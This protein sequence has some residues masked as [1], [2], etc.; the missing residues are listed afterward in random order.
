MKGQEKALE[1]LTG[2]LPV[3]CIRSDQSGEILEAGPFTKEFLGFDPT[4]K[5]LEDVFLFTEGPLDPAKT[6]SEQTEAKRFS[7]TSAHGLP[8]SMSF[9]FI[10]EGES[11][12]ILGTGDPNEAARLR[13]ELI[14]ANNSLSSM[15][16]EL[17]KKN[18]QLE[19][20]NRLKNLFLGMA[21]HD[22]R[23]P[24][25]AIL[26][27]T[28]F[29]LDEAAACLSEEHAGFLKTIHA[30]TDLMRRIIDDFLDVAMIESGVFQLE[31]CKGDLPAA[32]RRCLALMELT[33]R[34]RAVKLE[35]VLDE[36]LPPLEM[37]VAKI[38]QVM[39]N[40]ISNAIEH[41]PDGGDVI[42]TISKMQDEVMVCVKDSGPGI[43][44]E[45]AERL[46]AVFGRGMQKK[47]RGSKS[48]GLGLAISKK[49]MDAHGGRIWLESKPGK[50]ACFCFTLPCR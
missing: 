5:R 15:T 38:E 13:K 22:L 20:L 27:Y 49:I 12:L 25:S 41:S 30:S 44:S 50:G 48:T 8:E 1:L 7:V 35:L 47:A 21:A 9:A 2:V 3:F 43:S 42:I 14:S 33:A 11:F 16:R 37:D 4:G 24:V 46:F 31:R 19:E 34:K 39:N 32:A 45:D 6:A 10:P 26:S 36:A 23:K 28:E 17:Q 29:L 40:L 18:I